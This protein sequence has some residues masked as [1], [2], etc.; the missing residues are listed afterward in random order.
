[1]AKSTRHT[2]TV[3]LSVLDIPGRVVDVT[4][5]SDNVVFHIEGIDADLGTEITY[6]NMNKSMFVQIR[7]RELPQK[8]K[9]V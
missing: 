3:P 6:K 5:S 2:A 4:L 9:E 7:Y 1:M 8:P